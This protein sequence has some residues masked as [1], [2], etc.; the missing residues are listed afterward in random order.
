MN[1]KSSFSHDDLLYFMSEEKEGSK[2]PSKNMSMF[3]RILKV[4]STG[5][6]YGKGEIIAEFDINPDKWFFSC[7]F[8]GDPVMPG[9]LGLDALWQISGFFLSWSG[10]QGKGRA[11]GSD[12]VRF[13]GEIIPSTKLVRYHIHVRRII[14]KDITMIITDGDV[15]ADNK[16]IYSSEKLRV[17]FLP[18]SKGISA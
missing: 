9:C 3:D 18:E 17:A 11:L 10:H 14:K 16:H 4:N 15:Y 7:H 12:Q 8:P 6:R 2:L 1:M 13:F 5:G